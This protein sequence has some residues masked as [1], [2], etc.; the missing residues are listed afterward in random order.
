MA[1]VQVCDSYNYRL[2]R[3][4]MDGSASRA[5]VS[6]LA[7]SGTSARTDGVGA[8]AAF[9]TLRA[10]AVDSSDNAYIT[11]LG[12][13]IRRVSAAGVVVTIAGGEGRAALL[14]PLSGIVVDEDRGMLYVTDQ[15]YVRS[16][17]LADGMVSTVAGDP[18]Q[19]GFCDGSALVE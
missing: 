12:T 17:R 1:W 11:D 9:G 13:S 8:A 5:V 18:D 15:H 10:V 3:V 19:A 16:V 7:G 6:T 4:T 14:P 2:R